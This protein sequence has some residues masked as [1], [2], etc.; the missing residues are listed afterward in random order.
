[1]SFNTKI[2]FSIATKAIGCLG[3]VGVNLTKDNIKTL[4][5]DIRRL[6]KRITRAW[7]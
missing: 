3:Y 1:M 2:P 7:R 5:K 4:L 6:N